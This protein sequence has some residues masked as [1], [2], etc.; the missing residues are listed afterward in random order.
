MLRQT[1]QS[2]AAP[3]AA[4]RRINQQPTAVP[5]AAVCRISQEVDAVLEAIKVNRVSAVDSV[6]LL[7]SRGQPAVN[8]VINGLVLGT[9]LFGRFLTVLTT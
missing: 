1:S 3:A 9:G 2:A 5:A 6:V 4:L 8:L 7:G